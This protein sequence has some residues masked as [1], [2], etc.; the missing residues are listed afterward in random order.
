MFSTPKA[1]KHHQNSPA[2]KNPQA[3]AISRTS[4]SF[5]RKVPPNFCGFSI[6][7]KNSRFFNAAQSLKNHAKPK[8]PH[9]IH[10]FNP[11]SPKNSQN[12]TQISQPIPA[13]RLVQLAC[14][15]LQLIRG[16]LAFFVDLRQI[17]DIFVD[18]DAIL[19]QHRNALI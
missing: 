19:Y 14:F 4:L 15:T 5:C 17:L 2:S 6:F 13:H 10:K 16:G 3:I 7:T 12:P 18:L 11:N 9:K 1:A 8:K